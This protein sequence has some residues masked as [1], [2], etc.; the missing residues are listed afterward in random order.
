MK[1]Q[2]KAF[3]RTAHKVRRPVTADVRPNTHNKGE[4]A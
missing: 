2:N 4:I 3:H 1:M